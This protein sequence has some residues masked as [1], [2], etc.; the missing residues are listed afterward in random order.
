MQVLPVIVARRDMAW[1]YLGLM[2]ITCG[3]CGSVGFRP[4][5]R[6]IALW[7]WRVTC[8]CSE[9]RAEVTGI[10]VALPLKD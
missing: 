2:V 7:V 9:K 6:E 4:I 8:P 3:A 1:L 5:L 10:S